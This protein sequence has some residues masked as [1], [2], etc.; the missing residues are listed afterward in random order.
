MNTL[1]S[2]KRQ[3]TEAVDQFNR[4]HDKKLVFQSEEKYNSDEVFLRFRYG[5][6]IVTCIGCKHRPCFA[7]TNERNMDYLD[8]FLET[9][10]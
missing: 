4:T 6:R 8:E 3:I 10:K 5:R 9:L 2:V 7:C 1:E